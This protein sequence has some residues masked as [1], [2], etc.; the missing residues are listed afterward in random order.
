MSAEPEREEAARLP[1]LA[2]AQPQ[3]AA[4]SAAVVEML[5]VPEPSPPVPAVSTRSS[6]AGVTGDDVRAHRA[7]RADELVDGLALGAQRDE[8]AGDLG[9][10]GLAAHHEPD[11]GLGVARAQRVAAR[12]GGRSS[13]EITPR[14]A[15]RE[16]VARDHVARGREH[17][18]GV[19]LHAVQ[20]RDVAVAQR[21]DL[22]VAV[23]RRRDRAR[24]AAARS[25]PASGSGR[26]RRARAGR[27]A[28]GPRAIWSTVPT[29]P[30]IRRR[31]RSTHAA[32][33]L[34]DALV[35]EAHAEHRHAAGEALD[36]RAPRRPPRAGRPGPGEIDE[37]RRAR[38][39]RPPPA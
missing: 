15:M 8:Q 6:R 13:R 29:L 19:E 35:A 38:A 3:A 9:R 16:E 10:I 5:N 26:P 4:T 12:A 22:A 24:P 1:C 32:V 31:A 28:A 23:A 2:T 11:R 7:R 34:D 18:L 37:V 25:P 30:C 14:S 20:V 21:H 17:R 33:D 39:P 36:Q 27:R